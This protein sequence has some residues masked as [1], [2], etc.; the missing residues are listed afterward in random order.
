MINPFKSKEQKAM[1][2]KLALRRGIRDLKKW[3]RTLDKKKAEMIRLGQEAKRQGLKDQY[4]LAFNGLKNI[5]SQQL[6]SKKMQLQLEL[7]ETMRDLAQVSSGFVGQMGRIGK[8]VEKIAGKTDFL[9]NQMTFEKGMLSVEGMMDQL[10]SFMSAADETAV[11]S[12]QQ[13][14]VS[15][16]EIEQMFDITSVTDKPQDDLPKISRLNEMIDNEMK[17]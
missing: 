2:A 4:A 11:P 1:E 17:I 7:V 13:N 14:T 12:G 16:E 15:D 9:K 8:E 10:D 6:R 5:M 3:D